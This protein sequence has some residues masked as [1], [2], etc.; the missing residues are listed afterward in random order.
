LPGILAG[1]VFGTVGLIMKIPWLNELSLLTILIN[2]FNLLPMLPLDGGRV[3]HLL[4]FRRHPYLDVGFRVITALLLFGIGVMIGD[5]FLI[6]FPIVVA[7]SIPQAIRVARV[8]QEMR[9]TLPTPIATN[10]THGIPPRIASQIIA[11]LKNGTKRPVPTKILATQTLDV[12]EAIS[13]PSP[14]W[15]TTIGL[16]SLHVASIGV[17]VVSSVLL[18]FIAQRNQLPSLADLRN[19]YPRDVPQQ[20][21]DRVVRSSQTDGF[22]ATADHCL[23]AATFSSDSAASKVYDAQAKVLGAGASIGQLGPIILIDLPSSQSA[24]AGDLFDEFE[25]AGAKPYV[26]REGWASLQLSATYDSIEHAG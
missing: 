4:L 1:V 21:V 24:H 26:S 8:T 14:S 5:R 7:I 2:A 25:K 3:A 18:A 20:R 17:A 6:I 15:G 23:V 9:R 16:G 10:D 11:M 13:T 22:D 12:F 19:V